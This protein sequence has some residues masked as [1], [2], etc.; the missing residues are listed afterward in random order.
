MIAVAYI[1]PTGQI[2]QTSRLGYF[3]F[4]DH[5]GQTVVSWKLEGLTPGYHGA[6]VHE[7]GDC[8]SGPDDAGKIIPGGAAGPHYDPE[9]PKRHAGP[10]GQGHRGDL[11]RVLVGPDGRAASW[12]FLPRLTV[13]EIL[14]RSVIVHEGGD[15]YSDTPKLG[16]G[17]ARI[18]C[19]VIQ[20]MI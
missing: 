10:H 5:G 18:A 20:L 17:G 3:L 14:G 19:G 16:G 11:P 6:H 15:T 12:S 13:R 1:F 9:H 4:S 8:R 2:N 7:R